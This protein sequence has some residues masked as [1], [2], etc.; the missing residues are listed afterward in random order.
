MNKT[1]IKP[2]SMKSRSAKRP[3]GV[4]YAAVTGVMSGTFTQPMKLADGTIISPTYKSFQVDMATFGYWDNGVM[5]QEWL[6]WD[7]Q[8]QMKQ[9]GAAQ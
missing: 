7:N 6:F 5:T 2:A 4:I 8:A 9:I 3:M 1:S